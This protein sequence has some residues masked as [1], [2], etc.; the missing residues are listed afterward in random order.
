MSGRNAN[1]CK[2]LGERWNKEEM[3]REEK[4]RETG[5]GGGGEEGEE[6][7]EEEEEGGGGG[8]GGTSQTSKALRAVVHVNGGDAKPCVPWDVAL[9]AR[10]ATRTCTH[11]PAIVI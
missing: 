7:E 9:E 6:E 5:P 8:G 3:S 11:I 10:M 2:Q 1:D 4:I